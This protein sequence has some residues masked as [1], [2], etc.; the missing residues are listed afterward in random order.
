M[1]KLRSP[2]KM[3][4]LAIL[5]FVITFTGNATART[6]IEPAAENRPSAPMP[7]STFGWLIETVDTG[8]VGDSSSI[9]LDSAGGVHISL[10]RSFWTN[11]SILQMMMQAYDLFLLFK[12]GLA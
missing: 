9:A 7:G 11:K 2:T 6:D 4:G 5:M 3:F 1:L 12:M 10:L 8:G